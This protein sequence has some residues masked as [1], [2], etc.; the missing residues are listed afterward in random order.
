MKF[1]QKVK[2]RNISIGTK[3]VLTRNKKDLRLFE[4]R[5]EGA[6]QIIDSCGLKCDFP[7]YPYLDMPIYIEE[8]KGE[9]N[10]YELL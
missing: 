6:F 9:N 1:T 3:F 8:L 7:I 10:E 4:K 2:Y 5:I